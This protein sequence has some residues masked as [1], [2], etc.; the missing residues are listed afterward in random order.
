MACAILRGSLEGA[1]GGKSIRVDV[2]GGRIDSGVA[3]KPHGRIGSMHHPDFRYGASIFQNVESY[4]LITKNDGLI[5]A[6]E[7]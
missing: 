2:L 7:L 6:D 1:P 3:R 4:F 5:C